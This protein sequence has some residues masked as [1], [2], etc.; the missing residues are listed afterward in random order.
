[1]ELATNVASEVAS[2]VAQQVGTKS[3][4]TLYVAVDERSANKIDMMG[5]IEPKL[6]GSHIPLA[7]TAGQALN[8][9]LGVRKNS[10]A[11]KAVLRSSRWFVIEI[12]LKSDQVAEFMLENSLKHC[13]V[14]GQP[15]FQCNRCIDTTITQCEGV[16]REIPATGLEAWS[17]TFLPRLHFVGMRQWCYECEGT[18]MPVFLGSRSNYM[19]KQFCLQCWHSFYLAKAHE[20]EAK[21]EEEAEVPAEVKDLVTG[22]D[23]GAGND[24]RDEDAAMDAL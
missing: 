20:A 19:G 16:V 6:F 4:I 17:D 10:A 13:T 3:E 23:V 12:C 24:T 7:L 8:A 22:L 1:M 11:M 5:K 21:E 2:N 14:G 15:A 18:S 9:A